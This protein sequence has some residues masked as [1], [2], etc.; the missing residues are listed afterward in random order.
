MLIA[1]AVNKNSM[2]AL[3]PGT[4]DGAA[5]VLIFDAERTDN[6]NTRF[7]TE[8]IV[9][10]MADAWCEAL[11]CGFIYD[12]ALFEAIADAG[13]TRYFAADLTVRE[14]VEEMNAY[15]LGMIRD[16]VGGTGCREH[17]HAHGREDCDG[18]C[19]DCGADCTNRNA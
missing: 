19:A 11:L 5:G 13:I 15:R 12:A 16:Y 4:L 3:I 9:Q 10:E 6:P 8:N 17:G 1:A 7:V 18:V 14:A 2:D